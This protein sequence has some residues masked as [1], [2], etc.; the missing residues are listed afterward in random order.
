M[1][2]IAPEDLRRPLL[3]GTLAYAVTVALIGAAMDHD[4]VTRCAVASPILLAPVIHTVLGRASREGS[5]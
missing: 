2:R 1:T 5:E 3:V 4:L